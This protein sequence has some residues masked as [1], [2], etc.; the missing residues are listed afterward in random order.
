M[1]SKL[2]DRPAGK[3]EAVFSRT[4][5]HT[6]ITLLLAC[7]RLFM[8]CARALYAVG[9]QNPRE[10]RKNAFTDKKMQ[11]LYADSVKGSKNSTTKC[12]KF[13]VLMK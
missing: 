11:L 7:H 3:H 5:V 13:M 12:L 1:H 2:T 4:Q 10:G 9:I 8:S 6:G